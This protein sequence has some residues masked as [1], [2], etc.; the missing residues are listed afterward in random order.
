MDSR[1]DTN[2][3]LLS[4]AKFAQGSRE[5]GKIAQGEEAGRTAK[6]TQ[7]QNKNKA[8]AISAELLV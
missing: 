1:T 7:K 2:K 3:F 5:G 6:F 8:K 4:E